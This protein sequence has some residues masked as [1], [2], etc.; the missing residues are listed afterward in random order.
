MGNVPGWF[1]D[2]LLIF[3]GVC[4]L[5]FGLIFLQNNKLAP[6]FK[7]WKWRLWSAGALILFGLLFLYGGFSFMFWPTP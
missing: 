5:V 7:N 6:R 4:S 1:V 3:Y 2:A